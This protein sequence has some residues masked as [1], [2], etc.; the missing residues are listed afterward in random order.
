VIPVKSISSVIS[1]QPL[2]KVDGD[3]DGL[4]FVVEKSGLDDVELTGYADSAQE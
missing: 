1:M 4:V 3:P 2:P